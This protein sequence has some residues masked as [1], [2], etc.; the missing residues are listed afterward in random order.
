MRTPFII[1]LVLACSYGISMAQEPPRV[2]KMVP[3]KGAWTEPTVIEKKGDPRYASVATTGD[4][5]VLLAHSKEE[6]AGRK[7]V[8]KEIEEPKR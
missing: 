1:L 8:L 2:V 4:G 5:R 7:I 6:G 3:E